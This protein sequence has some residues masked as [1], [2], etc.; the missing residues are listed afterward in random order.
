MD[1]YLIPGHGYLAETLAWLEEHG[2]PG[3]ACHSETSGHPYGLLFRSA[4]SPN[5]PPKL[6]FPGDTL[7][8]DGPTVTIAD[9]TLKGTPS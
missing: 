6:A 5:E 9:P 8:A 1:T 4:A 3:A 2:H 7:I